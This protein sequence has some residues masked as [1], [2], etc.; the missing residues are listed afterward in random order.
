MRKT[1]FI[2]AIVFL[3]FGCRNELDKLTPPEE[4]V[5]TSIAD[6]KTKLASPSHGWMVN[7]QPTAQSGIFYMLMNFDEKGMVRVQSDVSGD[8]GAYYDQTIPYRLDIRSSIELIFESYGMLHYLFEQNSSTFGAEFEFYYAGVAGETLQ[9]V[10]KTDNGSNRTVISME[11][12]SADAAD[13]FSRVLSKNMLKYDTISS[14][15]AGTT[16][17]L[18][19]HDQ[20][21]SVFWSNNT[22]QRNITI[23]AVAQGTTVAEILDEDQTQIVDHTTGYGFFDEKM[24]LTEPFTFNLNAKNYTISEITLND[25]SKS[26]DIFCAGGTEKSPVYKGTIA[27]LGSVTLYKSLFDIKGKEFVPRKDSPYSVNVFFVADSTGVSLFQNGSIN[28]YFPKATGFA[29]NYGYEDED[30]DDPQPEYAVGLYLDG[31]NGK[32]LIYLRAFDMTTTNENKIKV[33][34]NDTYYPADISDSDRQH[35]EE[36]TDEIFGAGG[37]EVYALQYK[38]PNRTDLTVFTLYNPC[39]N[40][41]FLLVK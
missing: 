11:P 10:S 2:I 29:F 15:F 17:Q 34:F 35:L 30:E 3:V 28:T 39:N 22:A 32:R 14:I 18:S 33:S 12:A 7:Y 24:V 36:V 21:I 9:F 20:G 19:L 23:R 40:Y 31:G 25:F 13:V 8:D 16:Q 4:R 38:V 1:I 5:A 37:G 27:G 6:L 26:G 41:E